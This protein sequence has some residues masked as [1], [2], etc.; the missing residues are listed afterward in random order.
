[1]GQP[2]QPA[3]CPP[4]VR[5]QARHPRKCHQESQQASWSEAIHWEQYPHLTRNLLFW[6]LQH[7][8]DHAVLFNETIDQNVQGKPHSHRKK[9]INAVITNAIFWEDKQY[10][11]SYASHPARFASV[12]ASHLVTYIFPSPLH[13]DSLHLVNRLKN[14]YRRHASRFKSIGEGINPNNPSYQNLH[15]QVLAEFPFWEE[16]NQLWH[17]NPTYDARVFNATPRANWMGDFLSIIKRGG[18]TTPPTQD[19][20]QLQDQG[21]VVAHL[22]S[23]TMPNW[24]GK[25]DESGETLE[26]AASSRVLW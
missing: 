23:S 12:V 13:N 26:C 3:A 5:S 20:A 15:E 4:P 7:P 25:A 10:G 18:T 19:S 22:A 2:M 16:C 21:D 11:E 6:I 17:G 14:K 9:E 24:D 8:A 1:M